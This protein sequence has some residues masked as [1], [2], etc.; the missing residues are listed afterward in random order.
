MSGANRKGTD[1]REA[2]IDY[3]KNKISREGPVTFRDFM[4]ALLYHPAF[5]Y[6]TTGKGAGGERRDYYTN[7]DLGTYYGEALVHLMTRYL[8]RPA[9]SRALR[10]V[11]Y[12]AGSGRLGRDIMACLRFRYPDLY[13]KC[14]YL[15]VEVPGRRPAA[16]EDFA[17]A[18][19]GKVKH[20]SYPAEEACAGGPVFILAN[21]LID[22]FPVHRV[23]L[24]G[25]GLKELFVDWD[26]MNFLE[27][28]GPPSTD[29]IEGYIRTHHI[30]PLPDHA[31]EINLEAEKWIHSISNI[32]DRGALFICDYG[33]ET[34]ELFRRMPDG[35]LT[36]YHHH[37]AHHDPFIHIGEQDLTTHVDFSALRRA[38][39]AAGF[40]TDAFLPQTDLLLA[41]G[42]AERFQ[43]IENSALGE[44]EKYQKR[45]A[46][47][48][49]IHPEGMG[50]IFKFLVL[51]RGWDLNPLNGLKVNP[52]TGGL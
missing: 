39:E 27:K 11:E 28:P 17:D 40:R 9:S 16:D 52:F 38:G 36:C 1:G 20:R 33:Y 13:E 25:R 45:S 4:D 18:Y 21:E 32:V 44:I 5:G 31:F 7:P 19:P 8:G 48:Q 24:T 47:K 35:S 3:L 34:D 37:R 23:I 10:M 43:E 14:E 50:G 2:L 12:G 30:V 6:Y 41:C 22:A 46:I 15:M 51:S 42:I 29:A 26:G 49:L